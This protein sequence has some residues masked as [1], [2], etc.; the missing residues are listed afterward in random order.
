VAAT[1]NGSKFNILLVD[2]RPENLMAIESVLAD[3]GQNIVKVGSGM[4]ALRE[5]LRQDFVVILLDV[6]MP[7]MD[8]FETAALIRQRRQSKYTPII[9]VTAAQSSDQLRSLGYSL[10]AVDYVFVPIDPAILRAKVA[11]FIELA[12]KADLARSEVEVERVA[13]ERRAALLESR[14]QSLFNRLEVGIFRSTP[15]GRLLEANP[16][17]LRLIGR[18]S[19][20]LDGATSAIADPAAD[21]IRALLS[22][23]EPERVRT[24]PAKR[25]ER[26][27]VSDAAEEEEFE[28]ALPDG[29]A[30]VVSVTKALSVGPDGATYVEGLVTDITK[31]KRAE[32]ERERLLAS[33][34]AARADAEV[35]NRMKDEFLA[36]LSHELR[37]P[38]NAILGWVQILRRPQMQEE[39]LPVG[40]E[41]IE[42]NARVQTRLI[43]D[44]L[45]MSRIMS[46][47]IRL[48]VQDLELATVVEGVIES[49]RP[50]VEN[51]RLTIQTAFDA[52]CGTVKA[53][54]RRLQQVVWN[55]LSNAIKFTPEGGL[56][57]VEV[58][59]DG[60]RI[61]IKIADNGQGISPEFLPRIF[62][63]FRQADQS[64]TRM[65][66]G[67]GLGLAIV[68]HLVE[69]HGGTVS[70]HSDGPGK[71]ACF[72]LLLP[73]VAL[74]SRDE[75]RQSTRTRQEPPAE[76]ETNEAPWL[77]G[78]HCL[79]VDDD[80]DSRDL[81]R[82]VLEEQSAKV[83]TAA[84]ALQALDVMEATVPT[85][86]V[87]DIG[88][89]NVDGYD[90]IAR[91]RALPPERGGKV[92]AI[93]V[94]A[95]ARSEDRARALQA[96]Y[97][98]YLSKPLEP[99]RLV[100]R[101]AQ[102]AGRTTPGARA[103]VAG[104]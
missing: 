55:L 7:H 96:G 27:G 10:G 85:V 21:T 13:A 90:L 79:V 11:A 93:A 15:D 31:R 14:L 8:G 19:L 103:Q 5:V 86:L 104:S 57:R 102:L 69:L 47:K 71:G 23:R 24:E 77:D 29:R 100:R 97:D 39:Q 56:V 80:A 61:R 99:W 28:L 70:A 83:T 91:I 25:A 22:Y 94:T 67:L 68:R 59:R 48:D 38:L 84:S 52:R 76:H 87:S 30:V 41:T 64:S 49:F 51:K 101:V 50:A 16:A 3:L 45:D 81:M 58:R 88:M 6:N 4:E 75:L 98:D 54:S 95:F 44:L 36:T 2:D 62:E 9:F 1:A 74:V 40:L 46:G 20:H 73:V 53:D 12:R 72:E 34:R 32:E 78:V 17:L 92:R 89:A 63:R 37:T 33:E 18:T 60:S 42:R 35:A 26:G 66:G 82:R 43:E 65:H